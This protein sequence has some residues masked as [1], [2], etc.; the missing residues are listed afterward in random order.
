MADWPTEE[1]HNVAATLNCNPNDPHSWPWS[2]IDQ[3][4]LIKQNYGEEEYRKEIRK[5][6]SPH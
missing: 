2:V 6:M 3:L 1:Q 5:L 4:I